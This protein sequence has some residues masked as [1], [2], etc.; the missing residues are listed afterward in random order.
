MGSLACCGSAGS[1]PPASPPAPRGAGSG[2]AVLPPPCSP[3]CSGPAVTSTPRS[4]SPSPGSYL[5]RRQRLAPG[6]RVRLR[7][8]SRSLRVANDQPA[9]PQPGWHGR[10]GQDRPAHGTGW[11]HPRTCCRSARAPPSRPPRGLVT[12][13]RWRGRSARWRGRGGGAGQMSSAALPAHARPRRG[14]AG[15]P[16]RQPGWQRVRAASAAKP[17][18]R[19]RRTAP[20]VR[21]QRRGV[22]SAK[23]A[24]P[25]APYLALY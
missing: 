24:S 11:R 15:G 1:R 2:T 10:R 12:G 21:L 14:R 17:A 3:R 16:G 6:S 22:S 4:S 23:A 13:S 8:L 18:G 19:E 7:P 9:A 5:R 20:G 25:Q